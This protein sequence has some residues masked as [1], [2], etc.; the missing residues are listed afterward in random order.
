VILLAIDPGTVTGWAWFYSGKL[1]EASFGPSVPDVAK[2]DVLVIE[3]P[4][5]Y[6]GSDVDPNT[7]ITLAIKVGRHIERFEKLGAKTQIV[8]PRQW[9][10]QVP[11]KIHN[12]RVLRALPPDQRALVPND[13]NAI[14]AVGLGL[15]YLTGKKL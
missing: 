9:K 10:G 8:L 1:L 13:H 12:A 6:P 11:K 2:P 5:V 4:Q 14:D 7:L 3:K 15:F